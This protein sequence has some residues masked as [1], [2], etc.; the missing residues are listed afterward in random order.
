[1][2]LLRFTPFI[3]LLL[4]ACSQQ[5]QLPV[6]ANAHVYCDRYLLYRMCA[7]DVSNNGQTDFLYFEDSA[8][9]F[10]FD[11]KKT[12]NVPTYLTMH[13]CAQSM[14]TS[15]IDA[16]SLLLTVN[17]DMSFF[18]RTEIKNKIF[19]HYIRYVPRI[20]RCNK[21]KKQNEDLLAEEDGFGDLDNDD[22]GF[23]DEDD[24]GFRD[25]EEIGL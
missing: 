15:L 1:M 3:V 11:P 17:D 2:S 21:E 24:F 14:D 12:N 23:S 6:D 8:E 18:R 16:T 4:S 22:F 7:L 19:Y 10:L 5:P 20:N 13:K 9:I 25:S